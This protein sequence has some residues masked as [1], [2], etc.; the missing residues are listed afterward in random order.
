[1]VKRICKCS[2]RERQSRLSLKKQ[3]FDIKKWGTMTLTEFGNKQWEE[4]GGGEKIHWT[5]S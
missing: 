1:M 3:R 4:M 2:G 5:K